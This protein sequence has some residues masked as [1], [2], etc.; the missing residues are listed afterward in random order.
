MPSKHRSSW[1]RIMGCFCEWTEVWRGLRAVS[2][3]LV[4][5]EVPWMKLPMCLSAFSLTVDAGR[6]CLR[7]GIIRGLWSVTRGVITDWTMSEL[8][9]T[10]SNLPCLLAFNLCL[11]WKKKKKKKKTQNTICV[12]VTDS[13]WSRNVDT[14]WSCWFP[15]KWPLQMP[16]PGFKVIVQHFG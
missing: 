6:G 9:E 13:L 14:M 10:T 1:R 2:E 16:L 4:S 3:S 11:V 15:Q 5:L 7:S 12:I 8:F